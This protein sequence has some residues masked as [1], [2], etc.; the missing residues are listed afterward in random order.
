MLLSILTVAH[1]VLTTTG[2]AGL[3]V[4]N[5]WLLLLAARQQPEMQIASIHA[6]RRSAQIFGPLLGVGA[7]IGFGLA[8]V[9]H[10]PLLSSWLVATYVLIILALGTQAAIMV[11]WQ[12]RSNHFG[13]GQSRF[14]APSR[15]RALGRI[16][17]RSGDDVAASGVAPDSSRLF[18]RPL[19]RS[20][21]LAPRSPGPVAAPARSSWCLRY[22]TLTTVKPLGES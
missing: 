16:R 7:L 21:P 9:T 11:P 2:Y 10:Q 12:L 3:I 6:W 17:Q 13:R 19:G 22:I 1:V 18:V 8:A 5:L 20:A 15:A 4:G 14:D